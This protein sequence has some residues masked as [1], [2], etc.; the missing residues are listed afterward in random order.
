MH[1]INLCRRHNISVKKIT[2]GETAPMGRNNEVVATATLPFVMSDYFPI[3]VIDNPSYIVLTGRRDA[4]DFST[5]IMPLRGISVFL[6]FLINI[7]SRF[8]NKFAQIQL[9]GEKLL[10]VKRVT[11]TPIFLIF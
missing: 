10:P 11:H 1:I 4:I 5:N 3:L 9:C 2:T 6:C 8:I 7:E